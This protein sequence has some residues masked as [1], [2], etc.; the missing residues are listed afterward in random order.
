MRIRALDCVSSYH[1]KGMAA[2]DTSR[3]SMFNFFAGEVIR[4]DQAAQGAHKWVAHMGSAHAH[5]VAGIA[6]VAQTQGAISLRTFDVP[7]GTATELRSG[8]QW[9]VAYG[10]SLYPNRLTAIRSD[11]T[12][13]VVAPGARPLRA[14]VPVD[15][16]RLTHPGQFMV[17]QRSPHEVNLVHH[18]RTGEILTT[19]VQID[20]QGRFFIERWAELKDERFSAFER[21]L[22][23]LEQVIKLK[24]VE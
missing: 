4:K 12:L 13:S 20:D 23:A 21:L 15:R 19:P 22:S 24:H 14:Y 18:S 11:F 16:S 17:E 10:S 5:P 8:L 3:L 7:V 6:G 9:T 1:T 2:A